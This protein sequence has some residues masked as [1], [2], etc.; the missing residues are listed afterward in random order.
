MG[1]RFPP[2]QGPAVDCPE[3]SRTHCRTGQSHTR[4]RRYCPLPGQGGEYA[5]TCGIVCV[6]GGALAAWTELAAPPPWEA[7]GTEHASRMSAA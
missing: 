5:A 2:A 1:A 3:S 6:D 7:G 4:A